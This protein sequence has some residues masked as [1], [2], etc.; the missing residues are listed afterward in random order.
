MSTPELLKKEAK[1]QTIYF[2]SDSM[3]GE[4][5]CL[6]PVRRLRSGAYRIFLLCLLAATSS[7]AEFSNVFFA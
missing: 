7:V 6:A 3:Q 5:T 2:I 4:V 1:M